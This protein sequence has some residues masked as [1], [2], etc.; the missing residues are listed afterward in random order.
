[1]VQER[2]IKR[3]FLEEW[4]TLGTFCGGAA[5]AEEVENLEAAKALLDLAFLYNKSFRNLLEALAAIYF[6]WKI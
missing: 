6:F 2:E 1:M 3:T 5:A 4:G